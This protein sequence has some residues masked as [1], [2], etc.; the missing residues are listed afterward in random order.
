MGLL[1]YLGI[2]AAAPVAAPAP[3]RVEPP[4]S[5]AEG[6]VSS[7]S[8]WRGFT[9]IGGVSK[10]GVR[11]NETTALSIPATLQALRVLCGVFAMAPMHLYG[12]TDSGRLRLDDAPAEILLSHRPNAHQSPFDLFE[13]VMS[14]ILLAGNFYAYV[15]RNRRGEPVAV[16]RLRPGHVLVAEYFDRAEGQVLFYDATLPDGSRERFAARDIWH[17]RGF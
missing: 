1:S 10:A 8:Q 7:P 15:S 6:S 12:R 13:M 2:G 14:D 9:P 4:L 3:A 17:V 16:T 11:V 5:A